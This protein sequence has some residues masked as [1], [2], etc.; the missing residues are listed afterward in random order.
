MASRCVGRFGKY[1]DSWFVRVN[2]DVV[3]D[4]SFPFKDGESVVIQIDAKRKGLSILK[5]ISKPIA[6]VV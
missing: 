2:P 5:V 1:G 4:T 3:N 6:R